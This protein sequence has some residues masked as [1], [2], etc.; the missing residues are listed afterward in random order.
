[1]GIAGGHIGRRPAHWGGWRER[2]APQM[3]AKKFRKE[4]K[5]LTRYINAMFKAFGF[6]MPRNARG[7]ARVIASGRLKFMEVST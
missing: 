4:L 5:R 6:R 7:I 3:D 1:M 2:A